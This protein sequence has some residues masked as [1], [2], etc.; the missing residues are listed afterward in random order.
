MNKCEG[1]E[2]ELKEIM[3]D[4]GK[5]YILYGSYEIVVKDKKR[6][7]WAEVFN[8]LLD[9]GFEI[10]ITKKEG[11]ITITTKQKW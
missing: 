8:W 10:F 4:T 2:S 7:K 11:K 6:F 3:K 5:M 1:N 9:C